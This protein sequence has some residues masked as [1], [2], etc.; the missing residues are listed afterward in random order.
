MDLGLMATWA[1]N[2]R[3]WV[4]GF[5]GPTINCVV[6]VLALRS[7]LTAQTLALRHAVLG[8]NTIVIVSC[9][10]RTVFF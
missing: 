9:R 8:T 7:E 10:V 6:L 1:T 4:M 2:R 3:G 5:V